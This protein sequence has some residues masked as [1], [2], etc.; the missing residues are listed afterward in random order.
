MAFLAVYLRFATKVETRLFFA[1][2]YAVNSCNN[3]LRCKPQLRFICKVILLQEVVRALYGLVSQFESNF[4]VVAVQFLEE[5]DRL[6]D[7]QPQPAMTSTG[8]IVV[9]PGVPVPPNL[10]HVS[11]QT[12]KTKSRIKSRGSVPNLTAIAGQ[13]VVTPRKK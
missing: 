3:V 2:L 5:E 7:M 8:W 12:S 11:P 1:L 9:T 6:R 4:G 10:A 13:P